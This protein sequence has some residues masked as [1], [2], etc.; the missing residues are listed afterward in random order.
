MV[1]IAFIP[2]PNN[3][4]YINHKDENKE[5]NFVDNLEWCTNSYNQKYGNCPQKIAEKLSKKVFQYSKD[6]ELLRIWNSTMEC[7]RNGFHQG[8]VAKCCRNEA[9]SHKGYI[10]SYTEI[11]KEQG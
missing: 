2:N 4:P 5:N 10:W 1:A 6:G 9:K 7:K 11:K 3:Y 8:E